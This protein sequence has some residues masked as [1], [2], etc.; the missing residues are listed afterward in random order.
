MNDVASAEHSDI[1]VLGRDVAIN[2]AGNDNLQL[3]VRFTNWLAACGELRT[4][5]MAIP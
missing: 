2:D 5:G 4:V 3:L 1:D